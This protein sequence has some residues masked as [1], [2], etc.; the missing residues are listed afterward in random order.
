MACGIASCGLSMVAV[1]CCCGAEI[2]AVVASAGIGVAIG[3]NGTGLSAGFAVASGRGVVFSVG[4]AVAMRGTAVVISF[5]A[6]TDLWL[7]SGFRDSRFS[8]GSRFSRAS[9]FLAMACSIAGCDLAVLAVACGCGAGICTIV[10]SASI[11]VAMACS[12]AGLSA[13]FT[14]AMRG[15]VVVVSLGVTVKLWLASGSRISRFP[16]MVCCGATGCGL[17]MVAVACSCG[18]GICAAVASAG[19]AVVVGCNGTRL[20]AGFAIGINGR[21]IMISADLA[22]AIKGIVMVMVSFGAT[23]ELWLARG[24]RISRD[25]SGSRT[26]RASRFSRCLVEVCG[27]EDC[28]LEIVAV[29]CCGCVAGICATVASVGVAVAVGLKLAS[30]SRD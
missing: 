21:G 19:V 17:A 12:G 29:P 13:G 15:T 18:A 14:M 10:V 2:C 3:C 25:S 24:S 6:T 7:A 16:A 11:G 22:V 8:S 4:F 1:A 9:R 23:V 20:S 27:M 28:G 5:G 30:G 26:S